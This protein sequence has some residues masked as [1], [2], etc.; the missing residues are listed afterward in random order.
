MSPKSFAF[1]LTVPRDPQSLSVVGALASHSATY[2][3]MA[4]AAGADFVTR[5]EGTVAQALA[6]PGAP[7]LQI[8]VTSD[9]SGLTFAID[10]EPVSAG[11][12]A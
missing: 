1:K 9:A 11:H 6:S 3:G 10:A 8:I 2:A 12:S 5:V 7:M 4:A